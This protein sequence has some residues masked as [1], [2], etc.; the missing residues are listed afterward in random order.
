M[1]S[2]K[3]FYFIP[4]GLRDDIRPIEN[5]EVSKRRLKLVVPGT[6]GSRRKY[7]YVFKLMDDADTKHLIEFVLLGAPEDD[8]GKSIIRK[9]AE[10]KYVNIK[11]FDRFISESEYDTYMSEADYIFSDFDVKYLTAY[12]QSETYGIS[13]ETGVSFLIASYEKLA[14]LPENFKV[15]EEL[16]SQVMSFYD[17]DSLKK[18][19][20]DLS[21]KGNQHLQFF[22][23]EARN[24]KLKLIKQ[25]DKL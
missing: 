20:V 12:G 14:I 11:T 25:I 3:F 23:N 6:V 17:F 19:I 9:V 5:K 7:D 18:I 22:R 15:M 2:N 24:N 21:K 4:F 10:G 1:Y 13:K 16:Q 8:Y